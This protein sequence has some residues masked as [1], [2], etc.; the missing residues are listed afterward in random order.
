MV[1]AASKPATAPIAPRGKQSRQSLA[2]LQAMSFLKVLN[3]RFVLTDE[4]D[5]FLFH[6]LSSC[7][8]QNGLL[9][10]EPEPVCVALTDSIFC[11]PRPSNPL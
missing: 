4:Q 5:Y 9:F 11:V 8:E 1:N 2:V 10:P 3:E 7:I 6:A